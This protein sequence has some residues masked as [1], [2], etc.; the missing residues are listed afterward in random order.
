[1]KRI[2]LTLAGLCAV[3][4]VAAFAL[5]M[6]G[7][8]PLAVAVEPVVTEFQDL[9]PSQRAVITSGTAHYPV[10]VRQSFRSSWF[11]PRPATMHVYPLFSQGD[12][13]GREIQVLV[14]SA[15]EPDR[16][17]GYEDKTIRAR[18]RRPT[19]R[20]LTRAV[21]KAYEQVEYSFAEPFLLL[22]E[23]EQEPGAA[24]GDGAQ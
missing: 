21:L 3:L 10:R 15:N 22:V 7:I 5:T 20:W 19:T 11:K 14:L 2:M 4:A 9:D 23:L 18:V 17:L 13:A 1:M 6:A 16:L 8:G 24:A 12:T